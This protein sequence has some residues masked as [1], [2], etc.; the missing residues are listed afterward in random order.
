MVQVEKHFLL[1]HN[2][3]LYCS[4]TKIILKIQVGDCLEYLNFKKE[5]TVGYYHFLKINLNYFILFFL[6]GKQETFSN[7]E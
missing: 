7:I 4:M 3:I 5:M 2:L 1:M 6:L